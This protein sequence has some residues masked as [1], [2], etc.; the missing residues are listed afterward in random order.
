MTFYIVCFFFIIFI[1]AIKNKIKKMKTIKLIEKHNIDPQAYMV[2]VSKKAI[3]YK[4]TSAGL[5]KSK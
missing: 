3:S 5:R 2:R 4:G 1:Y